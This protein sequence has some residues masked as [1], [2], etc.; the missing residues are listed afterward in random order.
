M[1]RHSHMHTCM[2]H[3]ELHA[4]IHTMKLGGGRKETKLSTLA[5]PVIGAFSSYAAT[6]CLTC[7]F[8]REWKSSSSGS[9]LLPRVIAVSY[10]SQGLCCSSWLVLPPKVMQM[11]IDWPVTWNHVEVWGTRW[12][13][14]CPSLATALE[15]AAF[16][17]LS[18]CSAS[19]D[20]FMGQL[21]L[22][23]TPRGW[24]W[25]TEE[26]QADHPGPG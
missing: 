9:W 12:V 13:A 8:W 3:T 4:C 21:V 14:P 17:P 26:T 2:H 19:S 6:N 11:S 1:Y 20:V 10:G 15:R 5:T 24:G 25:G 18:T 23:F 16:Y 22:P 7:T